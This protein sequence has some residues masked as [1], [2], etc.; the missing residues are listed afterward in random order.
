MIED[1]KTGAYSNLFYIRNTPQ[2]NLAALISK[3]E[4]EQAARPE[5]E[6]MDHFDMA[7]KLREKAMVSYQEAKDALENNDWDMMEAMISLEREGRL[8]NRV[9]EAKPLEEDHKN[10]DKKTASRHT[11][12][13]GNL[14]EVLA[15]FISKLTQ[16]GNRNHL[17]VYRHEQLLFKVPLTV[18]ILLLMIGFWLLIPS[19]LIGWFAGIR[20]R[21]TGKDMDRMVETASSEKAS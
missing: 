15:D 16:K 6:K 2:F 5:E 10:A 19:M 17:E 1:E 13:L 7:E 11:E 4:N 14:L 3:Y 12:S 18:L 20:Y 8:N 9:P 21:V